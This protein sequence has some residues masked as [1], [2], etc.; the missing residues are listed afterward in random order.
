MRKL[1]QESA[2]CERMMKRAAEAPAADPT[3]PPSVSN[4]LSSDAASASNNTVS[5]PAAYTTSA[6]TESTNLPG[7]TPSAKTS[8]SNI[9]TGLG[10]GILGGLGGYALS[11]RKGGITPWLL[12]GAGIGG[13]AGWSWPTQNRMGSSPTRPKQPD[14]DYTAVRDELQRYAESLGADPVRCANASAPDLIADIQSRLRDSRSFERVGLT[15]EDWKNIEDGLEVW[16]E[17]LARIQ[18]MEDIAKFTGGRT[19]I[20]LPEN[21]Q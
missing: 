15:E 17:L 8:P 18:K 20:R 3:P 19:V 11:G 5:S 9:L 21:E 6:S 14:A 16:P 7:T 1:L 13:L 2:V 4:P 12:G 10:I